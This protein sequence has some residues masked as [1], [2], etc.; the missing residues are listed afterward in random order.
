MERDK[1][2]PSL[3]TGRMVC[4][5]GISGVGKT[6]LI[7][8]FLREHRTWR[9]LSASRL[10][11]DLTS[12]GLDELRASDRPVIE[13]NQD[14]LADAIH[15]YR[16]SNPEV[17][18][19][20]DAHSIVDNERELVPVPLRVIARINPNGILFVFDDADQILRRRTEDPIRRR[21][22]FDTSRIQREQSLALQICLRYADDLRLDLRQVRATN[23]S[24]FESAVLNTT[25]RSAL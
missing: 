6:N 17:D 10:L 11:V 1:I 14:L 13:S 8:G 20:L 4:V 5:F 2:V 22:L 24:G 19:L 15:H 25:N 7:E 3:F 12:K 18:W 9:G 21:P 23:S 16:V